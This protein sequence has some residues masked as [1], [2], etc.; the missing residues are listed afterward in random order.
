MLLSCSAAALDGAHF[1]GV[2]VFAESLA[3]AAQ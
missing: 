3:P 1:T 2:A